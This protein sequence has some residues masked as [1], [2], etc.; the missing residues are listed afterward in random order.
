MSTSFESV[1]LLICDPSQMVRSALKG[2]LFAQ[3]FRTIND[4]AGFVKLHDMLAQDAVDLVVAAQQLEHH[5]IGYL[6]QEM[7]HQRV[8]TNPFVVII[9][10]LSNSDPDNVR[11]AIDSGADD[12]LLLP[13]APAALMTRI[14]NILQNRK[15]F[16]VT[17]DYIGPDRRSKARPGQQAAPILP[18][19]NPI[20]ARV[21]DGLDGTR[22]ERHVK[23]A[24]AALNR[25]KIERHAVQV[26]WLA[27]HIC[28]GIRDGTDDG[29]KVAAYASRL[30]LTAEDILV[31]IKGTP[32]EAHFGTVA[33]L[34]EAAQMA[35]VQT[36]RLNAAALQKLHD[37]SKAV[38][39]QLGGGAAAAPIRPPG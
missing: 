9:M 22:F 16:I 31:R 27:S 5:D 32:A 13:V 17:H 19:P 20:K 4:T 30:A 11:K 33:D 26:D 8:G 39:R 6:V 15:P 12:L 37:L 21:E 36:N 34:R 3:S 23:D 7:R 38:L 29:P 18:V 2:A 14:N 25:M 24:A 35:E 28:A 10:L 1:R